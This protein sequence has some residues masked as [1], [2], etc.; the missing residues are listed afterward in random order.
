MSALTSSAPWQAPSKDL[1]SALG[2]LRDEAVDSK[3]D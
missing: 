2:K 3:S 1:A